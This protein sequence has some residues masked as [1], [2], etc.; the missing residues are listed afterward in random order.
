[1]RYSDGVTYPPRA[2]DSIFRRRESSAVISDDEHYRYVLTRIVNPLPAVALPGNRTKLRVVLF[3]ML[4]PSTASAENDDPT[5]RRCIAYARDWGFHKL[6]VVNLFAY[7]TTYPAELALAFDPVGEANSLWLDRAVQSADLVVC[8]WGPKGRLRGR[9]EE[10]VTALAREKPLH[11][12][13]LTKDGSP[14]HPLYLRRELTPVLWQ[15]RTKP[16]PIP[17]H[18]SAADVVAIM[19]RTE[20]GALSWVKT[21]IPI[22]AERLPSIHEYV[23]RLSARGFAI[24]GPQTV[25]TPMV[26]LHTHVDKPRESVSLWDAITKPP[27][28]GR[29]VRP[30]RRR[31]GRKSGLRPGPEAHCEW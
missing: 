26:V 8:A 7:R 29:A 6:V 9:D 10:V 22:P 16:A 27:R 25:S 18:M 3:V 30:A 11:V 23:S 15:P 19:S 12:L 17:L 13:K 1:M 4:N 21:P 28:T 20:A 31:A 2:P 14:G 5:I 24:P